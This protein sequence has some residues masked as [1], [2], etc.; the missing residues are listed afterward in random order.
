M[1]FDKS[2]GF[3]ILKN[4]VDTNLVNY[5]EGLDGSSIWV[6]PPFDVDRANPESDFILRG[7]GATSS[8][9][10]RYFGVFHISINHI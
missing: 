10:P 6:I 4:L 8:T 9:P 1:L 5:S 2:N 7:G 3:L